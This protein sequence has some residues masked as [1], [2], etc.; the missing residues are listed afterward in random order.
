M[1]LRVQVTLGDLRRKTAD[2]PDDTAVI[3][4][5][6]DCDEFYEVSEAAMRYFPPSLDVPG[7]LILSGG[8]EVTEDQHLIPRLDVWLEYAPRNG[9]LKP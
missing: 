7:A 9:G 2:L 5:Y 6:G 8:Q 1:P 3:I 4:E